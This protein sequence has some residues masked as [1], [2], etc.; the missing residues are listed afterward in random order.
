ME[1]TM[2]NLQL[3]LAIAAAGA[4]LATSTATVAQNAGQST[5]GGS[6]RAL[7][8]YVPVLPS[9][10]SRAW[11][12]DPRKGVETR[13]VAN[14][15]FVITD[16]VWQSA[17]AV[18][19]AGVVVFDAPETYAAKIR[20]EIAA[21]T[22][23]PIT[24]LVYTHVHNDHIG[25]SAAFA[26]VPGLEIVAL[27]SVARFLE[28]KKDPDRLRPTRTFDDQLVLDR[29]GMRIELRGAH[30]HSDEGDLIV[31]IPRARFLMAIDTLAPGYGPFMGFDITSNFHEYMKVFDVLLGYDFHVFVGGHLTHIGNRADVE[32]AREFTRDVYNTVRRVH[33]ETDLMAVFA[34]TAQQIGGFDNKYLLFKRF[35]DVVAAKATAEIEQRWKSRLAGIDVFAEDHVRTALL[36]VRWDD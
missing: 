30:Y 29:G 24:T 27:T 3:T 16:G 32:V 28:E 1:R 13:E 22:S 35:L 17:F 7:T 4:L 5:A 15:V 25:G 11:A 10:L 21:V 6:G 9:T 31:Y 12:I 14:G 2:K 26:D 8:D 18:T 33:G 19:S 36:Y 20:A 23:Q 34:E